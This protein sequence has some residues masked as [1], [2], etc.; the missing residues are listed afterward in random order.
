[1]DVYSLDMDRA[2]IYVECTSDDADLKLVNVISINSATSGDS[3]GIYVKHSITGVGGGGDALRA[4]CVVDD[5]VGATA[6]GA[7]ISLGF[8]SSGTIT[9]L[10][11]AMTATLHVPATAGMTGTVCAVNAEIYSD[12]ATSDPAGATS[13]SFFRVANSGDATGAADVDDDA[14][15]FDLSGFTSGS[16]KMWYD[17]QGTAPANVEEWL[18]VR[19][20]AG[21]RWIGLYNA[22][23]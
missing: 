16:A 11:S 7:H 19:T 23:V 5:V 20:P 12:A 21:V 14:V 15:L 8:D 2:A 18:K 9:G 1:M 10:G 17:H 4:Y 22:V 13:I 6:R 3:R